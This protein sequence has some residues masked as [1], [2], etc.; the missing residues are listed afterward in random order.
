MRYLLILPLL[1]VAPANAAC[2]DRV[3]LVG[4]EE[5]DCVG[6]DESLIASTLNACVHASGGMFAATMEGA[7]EYALY[8]R[9]VA[10]ASWCGG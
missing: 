8:C 1:F 4:H 5:F 2:S 6:V 3:L 7:E 10:E 9:R